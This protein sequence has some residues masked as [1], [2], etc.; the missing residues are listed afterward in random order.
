M[1]HVQ[2]RSALPCCQRH[3]CRAARSYTKKELAPQTSVSCTSFNV[4]PGSDA[5]RFIIGAR[6]LAPA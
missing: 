4:R 6:T 3:D 1:D 2:P 5:A